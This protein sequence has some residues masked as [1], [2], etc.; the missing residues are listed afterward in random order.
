MSKRKISSYLGG[1]RNGETEKDK[2]Q[3]DMR[4][5][6]AVGDGNTNPKVAVEMAN[7][8]HVVEIQKSSYV[9]SFLSLG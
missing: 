1:E 8:T 5:E 6:V 3:N 4:V 7:R 9:L 2:V